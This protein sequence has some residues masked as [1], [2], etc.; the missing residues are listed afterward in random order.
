MCALDPYFNE[1]LVA[2]REHTKLF[3]CTR[4]IFFHTYIVT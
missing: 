2:Y 3:G 1:A 4:A